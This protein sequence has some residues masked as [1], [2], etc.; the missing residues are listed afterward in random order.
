MATLR[1]VAR[2]AGVSHTTV[3]AVVN[4]VPGRVSET[5]RRRVIKAIQDLNYVPNKTARQL[6]T[7]RS[8]IVAICYESS[9]PEVFLQPDASKLI[10]GVGECAMK[11]DL[12]ILFTPVIGGHE[13]QV[14]GSFQSRS[15]DGVIVVGPVPRDKAVIDVIENSEVPLVCIDSHPDFIKTSTVDIDNRKGMK[16]GTDYLVAAGHKQIKYIS[17]P[18]IYQC[19]VDRMHG[20][21][22]SLSENGIKFNQNMLEILPL[23]K[24]GDFVRD[25]LNSSS[26]PSTIILSDNKSGAVAWETITGMGLRVPDDITI[27]TFDAPLPHG[28]DSLITICPPLYEIGRVAMDILKGM[29]DGN[30]KSPVSI[31]IPPELLVPEV[32]ESVNI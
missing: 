28:A 25:L 12:S 6:A 14:I 2:I 19:F 5:T 31:R 24:I 8:G 15:V 17:Q 11:N 10:A 1:D 26:A 9:F 18:P 23:D 20:F 32:F 22:D 7:G 13:Q 3:A 21:E 4:N 29:I 27:M 16:I 30:R